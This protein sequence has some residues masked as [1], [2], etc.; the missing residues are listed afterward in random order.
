LCKE[1]Y[2][3]ILLSGVRM[4]CIT[5]LICTVEAECFVPRR[6][7]ARSYGVRSYGVRS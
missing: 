2:R 1:F 5:R 3:S 6:Y 4:I 7:G